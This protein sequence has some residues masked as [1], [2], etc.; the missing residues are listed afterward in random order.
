M[1]KYS[2]Q[3]SYLFLSSI[4]FL[5]VWEVLAEVVGNQ[6]IFP[7][8]LS[9][10][11]SLIEILKN[12]NF[13]FILFNTLKKSIICLIISFFLGSVL[14]ILS[15]RY[16]ICE[17]IFFPFINFIKSI[18]TIVVIILILIWSKVEFVPF[19]AGIMIILPIIYENIIG[20]IESIDRELIKMAKIYNV[21]RFL[22]YK[23]IYLP[24][25]YFYL[26]STLSS[27]VGL[28]LK[29]IIAGEVLAQDS[30]SIGGEIFMGKI[31]LESATIF[32]WIIVIILMNFL[33][34]V[35]IKNFNR[36]MNI[37]RK[38]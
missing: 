19:F 13:L 31:Y 1:K 29:V 5:I 9:I 24:S 17:M 26:S 6:M 10:F 18:P 38:E 27:I 32:A 2:Y 34:E 16:K 8:I 33:I 3:N 25:V 4:I 11:N 22:I 30:L 7:D 15:Y 37:W 35:T 12:E 36:K 23:D 20:G 14:G 21:S 28:T